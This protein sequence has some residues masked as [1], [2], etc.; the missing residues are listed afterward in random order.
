M[1]KTAKNTKAGERKE[2]NETKENVLLNTTDIVVVT[3]NN[4]TTIHNDNTSRLHGMVSPSP[5]MQ[6]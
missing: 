2:V 4:N 1:R 3:D 6:H 5:E